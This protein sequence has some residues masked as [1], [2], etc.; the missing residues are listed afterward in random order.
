MMRFITS[1]IFVVWSAIAL[2]HEPAGTLPGYDKLAGKTY[3]GTAVEGS[4][5]DWKPWMEVYAFWGNGR[6]TY[7]YRGCFG[8]SY[9][10]SNCEGLTTVEHGLVIINL[11]CKLSRSIEFRLAGVENV[12]KFTVDVLMQSEGNMETGQMDF[13]RSDPSQLSELSG[14]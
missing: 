6:T 11:E 7:Q 1:C 14:C 3:E 4:E 8:G 10:E 9:Y 2:G 12:D 5:W 13:V